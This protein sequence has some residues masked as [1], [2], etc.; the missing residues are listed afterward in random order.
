MFIFYLLGC[1]LGFDLL[2]AAVNRS[3]VMLAVS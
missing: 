2:L 1:F 3:V